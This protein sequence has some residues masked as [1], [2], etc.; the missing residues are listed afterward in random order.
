M[1][2]LSRLASVLCCTGAIVV[3]INIASAKDGATAASERDVAT[4]VTVEE[5]NN[6]ENSPDLEGFVPQEQGSGF[7][8]QKGLG[9]DQTGTTAHHEGDAVTTV[10][11]EEQNMVEN[12][13]DL[14]GFVPQEQG[15]GFH[16]T[17][18]N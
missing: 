11:A 16:F 10:T 1:K 3:S 7:Y 13:S 9:S 6:V 8:F 18:V 17:K 15:K 4:I 12:S 5:Q 14:E 2:K